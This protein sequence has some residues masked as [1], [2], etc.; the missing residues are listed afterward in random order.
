VAIGVKRKTPISDVRIGMFVEEL[1]RPWVETP[2]LFQ[3]IEVRSEEDIDQLAKYCDYVYVSGTPAPAAPPESQPVRFERVRVSPETVRRIEDSE[4]V[5]PPD[6]AVINRARYR[7]TVSFEREFGRA[8][9]IRTQLKRRVEAMY[10]DVRM[11]SGFQYGYVIEVIGDLTDSV[12]RN[13]SAHLLLGQL[14]SRDDYAASHAMNVCTVSLALGRHLGLPHE[15]LVEL[16]T[17]AMLI[18]IGILRLPAEILNKHGRLTD[19]EYDI[20]KSHVDYGIN[21][22]ESAGADIPAGVLDIVYTHH[23]RHDGSGYPRGLAGDAIPLGGR[24]VGIVD[25]YDAMTTKRIHQDGVSPTRTLLE[26]YEE[27][28]RLFHKDLVESFIQCLGIYPVGALVE[29]STGQVGLVI[30][31]TPSKRLR[32]KLLLVLDQDKNPYP[33]PKVTDLSAAEAEGQITISRIVPPNEYSIDVASYLK[34]FS[35]VGTT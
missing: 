15:Q 29:C 19:E 17:G 18:D 7:A 21:I 14:K 34:D 10:E 24:I 13:P 25:T 12:L 30:A 35:W 16:G 1:D 4:K 33:I 27:R 31:Q 32:P 5:A 23:E 2:F 6:S 28:D 22:L 9:S 8:A 11:G 3:G 20:V 26:L